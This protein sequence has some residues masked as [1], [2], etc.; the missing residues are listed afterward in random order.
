MMTTARTAEP[1]HEEGGEAPLTFVRR[2]SKVKKGE[3]LWL[4]SFSDMSLILMSFF[5]LQLAFSNPDRRKYDNLSSALAQ[6]PDAKPQDNLQS[7]A[8]KVKKVI[9]SKNLEKFAEVSYDVNGL[10]VEFK[11]ATLFA[12][13]SAEPNRAYAKVVNEVMATIAKTPGAYKLSFEGHTDDTPIMNSKYRSNWELSS[14]RGLALLNQFKSRGVSEKRMAV[15]A[16]AQ[17]RPKIKTDG[18]TGDQLVKARAAN[19]RVVIRI[20]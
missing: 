19:R 3:G 20:D 1:E 12:P 7:M 6:K 4:M 5:V 18:L 11:D 14:A 9:N 16:Y 2:K 15:I 17:T 8:A 10:S 13:G